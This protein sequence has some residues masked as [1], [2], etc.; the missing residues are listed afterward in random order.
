MT[1]NDLLAAA[2][3]SPERRGRRRVRALTDAE[4]GLYR[5]FLR[6]FAA[7]GSPAPDELADAASEF[8]LEVEPAL[9]RLQSAD[10]V[11]HDPAT[12]AI[13]VA[14]PFSGRQTAHRVRIE[15]REVYAMCALD[16]L[17]IAPM[18]GEPITIASR[19]PLTG[20]NIEVALEPDG[21]GSWEPANAVLVSGTAGG[22]ASCDACCPVLNFF[23]SAQNAERWLAVHA[24][25]RGVVVS[26]PDA[27][28]AGRTVFGDLLDEA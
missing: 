2:A 21:R 6:R 7:G 10:L 5:W 3:I 22:S 27:I 25:V 24:S 18:L 16:A 20:K 4:R 28:V 15:G 14:Y 9:D 11:H 1:A 19:D 26:L 23:A 8:E 12:G 17:G 13:L